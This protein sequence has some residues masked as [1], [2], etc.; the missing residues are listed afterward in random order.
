[1][2][3]LTQ[4]RLRH[5][6]ALLAAVCVLPVCFAQAETVPTADFYVATNGND[7]WTGT[8][9]EPNPGKT[10]GPFATLG[11][12]RD[13]VRKLLAQKPQRD[14]RVLF[15]GGKHLLRETV[16]FSRKDSAAPG[17][18]VVYA[19]YPGE[20]PMLTAGVP[21][22]GWK[23]LAANPKYLPA[24]AHGKVWVADVGK[25]D[26]FRA[27]F[28]EEGPLVRARGAGFT[29]IN[30]TPRGNNDYQTTQF[31]L[32]RV[33]RFSNWN[34]VE[35]RIVPSHYWTMNLLP[36][37]SID[38][39]T[40][41]LR[42]TEAGTYPLGRNG[43]VDRENAW[44]ENSLELLD[45]P[46]EWVLDAD[47]Q[48]LYLWPRTEKPEGIRAPGLTELIRVE[49]DIDY[50]GPVDRPVSGLKFQ[51]L[52]FAHGDS[53]PWHGRTGWGLQHDWECFD[54]P[55]ALLRFRGAESCSVEECEFLD[56]GHTAVRLDL[57]CQRIQ[58]TGNHIH[59]VGGVGVL[60]AGYGPGTKDVNK[61]NVVANNYIHHIGWQY[62]GSV[63]IFAWQSGDNHIAHNHI[64][65]I[66]YTAILSTGRISRAEP[67]PGE[68]SRT[69]RWHE[70]PA[71]FRRWD[72]YHREPYLHARRNI[73]EYNEVHNAM[74]RLGDGNCIYI[75]GSGGGTI[76]RYNY[77]H[78]CF[79]DYMNAV[80][81]CDDDQHQTL[82]QG[83]VCCR[84]S[85][86]GEG[87]ISK[88]DNDIIGNIVADLRPTADNH[89]GYIVFPYGDISGTKIEHNILYSRGKNQLL[90]YLGQSSKRRPDAPEWQKTE[91]NANVYFCTEDA[92]W[93]DQHFADLRKL[94]METRSL[95]ADPQFANPDAGDFTFPAD[96]PAAKLGIKP[97]DVSAAGLQAEY[98]QRF[99]GRRIRTQITPVGGEFRKPLEITIRCSD[100]Q[101]EI[102]YSLDGKEPTRS[103][104]LYA[105]P[106]VLSQAA[107]IRAK[108][109]ADGAIDAIGSQV[110]FTP[111]PGPI[112]QDFEAI[113]V[114]NRVLEAV[115]SEDE[116]LKRYTAQV[117]D[118]Q[119]AGGRHS[120]K[121]TDG[122]GQRQPF[123][124]HVYYRCNFAEGNAVGRFAIRLDRH[125]SFYYQ[126][127]HFGGAHF[128]RSY[129]NGPTVTILPGGK[130]VDGAK[131][132]LEL[133]TEQWIR[134]EVSCPL[135]EQ[136]QGRYEMRVFLPQESKPTV[137]HNLKMSP[138]FKELTWFGIVSK[139][140]QNAVY[141]VDDLSITVTP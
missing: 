138:D 41:L 134:F 131:T 37:E 69:V 23:K 113:P 72:W 91:T 46:G 5:L 114:G 28:D 74:E 6:F 110:R 4:P 83:N 47:Q 11:R 31:P 99:I 125:A 141:Y 60:L 48:Q 52:T 55:T 30:T 96:S 53:F 17:Q 71:E 89:R 80:I 22:L 79:G 44:L 111:P 3:R 49:G 102:R 9:A 43:M 100:P 25:A 20:R 40:G 93:A 58:V 70:T 90:Y 87:F 50:D 104:Q 94:G 7:G 115:T 18:S 66:P 139:A 97:L 88:G 59:D 51:G 2:P 56:T 35:L 86:W 122:P 73:I 77:C 36:V 124:P 85:G 61:Q 133:P 81:R 106:F 16:V 75:S 137:F 26:V 95:Q 117:S 132:L 24:A 34:E 62:W 84:T 109:F 121:F 29:P 57:Y 15:R 38:E 126:W 112:V 19:A 140:E 1:M 67:G 13:A 8:Q 12:A 82:M 32:G 120:L 65:N 76:V 118:E 123:T 39:K 45:E 108:A 33:S 64:S 63:G 98:R 14:I 129:V 103:S 78:D 54:K 68:C 101:A 127:R 10:D 130:L 128:E 92:H 136:A 27:L 107:L 42:T 21:V 135:G 116:K 119:A 105:G